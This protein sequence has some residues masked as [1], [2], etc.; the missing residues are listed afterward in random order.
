MNCFASIIL[1]IHRHCHSF[2]DTLHF[3]FTHFTNCPSTIIAFSARSLKFVLIFCWSSVRFL[4]E[5]T[6][7]VSLDIYHDMYQLNIGYI[8]MINH[9]SLFVSLFKFFSLCFVFSRAEVNWILVLPLIHLRRS[10]VLYSFFYLDLQSFIIGICS[11]G[12][13]V[14]NFV[15]ESKNSVGSDF[16]FIDYQHIHQHLFSPSHQP[17]SQQDLSSSD[18]SVSSADKIVHLMFIVA[19]AVFSVIIVAYLLNMVFKL[20]FYIRLSYLISTLLSTLG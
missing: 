10:S 6:L 2:R 14:K 8:S 11:T 7:Y 15:D 18:R 4:L 13:S 16:C 9:P 19:F 12:Q 5:K 20:F 17:L 3:I 1:K